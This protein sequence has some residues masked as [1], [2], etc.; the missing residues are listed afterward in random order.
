LAVVV[1]PGIVQKIHA[2]IDGRANDADAFL[3]GFLDSD[4]VAAQAEE[5]DPLTGA[6]KGAIPH[7]AVNGFY[8]RPG[9]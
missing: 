6:A 2:A 9:G 5:G 1:I 7:V 3:D 4:V 8:G